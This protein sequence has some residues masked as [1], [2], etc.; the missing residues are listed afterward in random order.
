MAQLLSKIV[1]GSQHEGFEF[2]RRS[3]ARSDDASS[4]HG[5]HTQGFSVSVVGAWGVE[6]VAAEC[7]ASVANCVEFVGLGAVLAGFLAWPIELDH[8]LTDTAKGSG[9]AAAIA[10][11]PLDGPCSF[12]RN[13]EPLCPSDG[14]VVAD[15][16]SRESFGCNDAGGVCIDD[17]GGDP[18][19]VWV[20]ADD[21]IDKFCKHGVCAS[22]VGTE[23]VSAGLGENCYDRTVMSHTNLV[24]R[25]LIRTAT[26]G[27]AGTGN[28]AD[29]SHQ[30]HRSKR[31]GQP[32]SGSRWITATNTGR[33]SPDR[34]GNTHSPLCLPTSVRDVLKQHT[35][36][37]SNAGAK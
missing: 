20:D 3:G 15:R 34:Q 21:V 25:L 24:D 19:S 30:M 14:F 6:P 32:L 26:A 23:W 35:V 10:C 16:I 5:V 13:G 2:V 11:G 12:T 4:G 28:P 17:R 22:L 18:I 1:R 9:K 33:P 31:S 7:L 36:I 27:Q 8:P 37:R 29:N